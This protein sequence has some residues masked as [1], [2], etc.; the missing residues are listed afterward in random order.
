M[1][2]KSKLAGGDLRIQFSCIC[3]RGLRRLSNQD[4]A[5][6]DVDH[7]VFAVC[8]GVGGSRGGEIA[9]QTAI[10]TLQDAFQSPDSGA[11]LARL[12][13]A[14]QYANRDIF[15]MAKHNL[16]LAGMATTVVAVYVEGRTAYVAHAGDSRLYYFAGGALKQV[17]VDHTSVHDAVRHG[18]LSLEEA[19]R[20]PKTNVISRALGVFPDVEVECQQFDFAVGARFFLCTDGVTRHIPNHELERL[21]RA[22]ERDP[23]GLCDEVHRICYERG[24]EDN[25]TALIVCLDASESGASVRSPLAAPAPEARPSERPYRREISVAPKSFPPER[26]TGS[27]HPLQEMV[28]ARRTRTRRLVAAAAAGCVVSLIAA[29]WAGGRYFAQA[30]RWATG[31]APTAGDAAGNEGLFREA[32][33][34]FLRGDLAAAQRK[35]TA[36]TE[37]EPKRAEYRFWLGKVELAERRVPEALASF[38]AAV[39]ESPN[40]AEGWLHVAGARRLAGDAAGAADALKKYAEAAK[41]A[42]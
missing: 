31:A 24:A 9:S 22:H 4:R 39:K 23:Q 37:R 18:D 21:V 25:F 14:V 17:T 20:I 33:A 36:L 38:E 7:R 8:D 42:P 16:D 2:P 12:E 26:T 34:E 19:S 5:W 40:F 1:T 29:F 10:E 30:E 28:E 3:D 35:F 11:P 41:A 6:A 13:R 15:E 32:Q 27:F